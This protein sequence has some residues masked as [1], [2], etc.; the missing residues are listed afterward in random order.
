MD[1]KGKVFI[2]TGA[3]S[4]IGRA[5]AIGL[6]QKGA[7]LILNG[8]NTDSLEQ[9]SGLLDQTNSAKIIVSGD[10]TDTPTRKEIA[11]RAEKEMGGVDVLINNAGFSA[12]GPLASMSDD[13]LNKMVRTN[14]LAP[15]Q[16]TRD[17]L[18]LLKK[19]SSGR[20][21]NIGS[22]FG[23]IAFPLF[24]GYSATKFGLRGFS[25]ALRRELAPM[26]IGVTYCAPRA[27]KTGATPAQQHLIEPFSMKLDD[28]Q[29]PAK[30]IIH[31]I[32]T[33][34]NTVYPRTG[35]KLFVMVQRLF[36]SV[37]DRALVKQ[38][39]DSDYADLST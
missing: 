29:V 3:G 22:M 37:I 33:D 2:I 32:E 16:M 31:A 8:R 17:M 35:E 23:D 28:A 5:L 13:D 27:T 30:N 34:K 38:L 21:V 24:A 7:K 18:G 25:D 39:L 15:M 19:S 36:P 12:V 20:I 1:I 14:L 11:Y 9:T 4:G 26:G 10:V 6:S